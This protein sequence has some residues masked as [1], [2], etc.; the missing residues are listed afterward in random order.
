[1]FDTVP[2]YLEFNTS[3][4]IIFALN[5]PPNVYASFGQVP[6]V[7]TVLSDEN[8]TQIVQGIK[9]S[10]DARSHYGSGT[11][12][13]YVDYNLNMELSDMSLTLT[14]NITTHYSNMDRNEIDWTNDAYD[15]PVSS[16]PDITP[17]IVGKYYI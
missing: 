5:L 6:D 17:N 14:V 12:T 10:F 9:L 13:R 7:T 4:T 15:P 11:N 16:Y 1:M 8:I 2:Q 3:S